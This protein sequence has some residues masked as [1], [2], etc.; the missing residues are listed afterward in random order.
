MAISEQDTTRMTRNA[1]NRAFN[2]LLV[3][4]VVEVVVVVIGLISPAVNVE[5]DRSEEK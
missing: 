3:V 5:S 1:V 2:V 4:V